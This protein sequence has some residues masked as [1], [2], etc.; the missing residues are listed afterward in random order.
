MGVKVK[1]IQSREM[2]T[3]NDKSLDI[4]AAI[5]KF[6]AETGNKAKRSI[7]KSNRYA[8]RLPTLKPTNYFTLSEK[9]KSVIKEYI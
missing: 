7:P 3:M 1:V 6:L 5:E 2:I 9:E 8:W 4:P